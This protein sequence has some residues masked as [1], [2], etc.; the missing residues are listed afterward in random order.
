MPTRSLV[1]ISWDLPN[2]LQPTNNLWQKSST[3]PS[4]SIKRPES[5]PFSKT[6]AGGPFFGHGTTGYL[7]APTKA[8]T[9]PREHCVFCSRL[10]ASGFTRRLRRW[11]LSLMSNI[12]P[13]LELVVFRRREIRELHLLEWLDLGAFIVVE[14][15]TFVTGLS[16]PLSNSET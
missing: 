15:V 13:C 5:P 1:T 11:E 9:P 7:W 6:A 8:G 2:C 16:I 12:L 4:P 10:R 14:R 3:L